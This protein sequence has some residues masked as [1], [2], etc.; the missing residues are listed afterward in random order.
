MF[1]GTTNKQKCDGIKFSTNDMKS[2]YGKCRHFSFILMTL[3]RSK[4]ESYY[5][6]ITFLHKI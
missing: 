1:H 6:D 2:G 4:F 5:R 3:A